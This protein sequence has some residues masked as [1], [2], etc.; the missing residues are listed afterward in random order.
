MGFQNLT[1]RFQDLE[2]IKWPLMA[3]FSSNIRK[4]L[5]MV[6]KIK[7]GETPT[8]RSLLKTHKSGTHAKPS[9][10]RSGLLLVP[11]TADDRIAHDSREKQDVLS[12]KILQVGYCISS[13]PPPPPPPPPLPQ[14]TFCFCFC[15]N[16]RRRHYSLFCHFLT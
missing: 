16:W 13:P 2:P 5:K 14:F 12:L 6:I 3:S 8:S 1:P 15:F 7:Y 10:R 9:P 11:K 4:T